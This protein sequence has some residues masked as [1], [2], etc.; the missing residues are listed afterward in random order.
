M[1]EKMKWA[2]NFCWQK[3]GIRFQP[4]DNIVGGLLPKTRS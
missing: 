3:N 2:F 4:S 1:Q